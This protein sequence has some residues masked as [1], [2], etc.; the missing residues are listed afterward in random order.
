MAEWQNAQDL[1]PAIAIRSYRSLIPGPRHSDMRQ[2]TLSSIRTGVPGLSR[3][4]RKVR[5][6]DSSRVHKK[7]L[8][9]FKVFSL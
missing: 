6:L 5:G 4:R 8:T 2:G 3:I 7:V 1:N 9:F